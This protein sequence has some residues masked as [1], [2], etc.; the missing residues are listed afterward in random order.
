MP[1]LPEIHRYMR[2][3]NRPSSVFRASYLVLEKN[4]NNNNNNIFYKRGEQ[5][6]K[7]LE[8]RFSTRI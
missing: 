4:N 1:N 8:G 5:P 3:Q 6:L 7:T 2:V